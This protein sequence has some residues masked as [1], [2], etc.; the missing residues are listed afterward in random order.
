MNNCAPCYASCPDNACSTKL[1]TMPCNP[2]SNKYWFKTPA[3]FDQVRHNIVNG[4]W[5]CN[6]E[7]LQS[8]NNLL[9]QR[10]FY[11][12][13][14]TPPYNHSYNLNLEPGYRN[15]DKQSEHINQCP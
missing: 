3:K 4:L 8:Q 10:N 15:L 12:G 5:L 13:Y 9:C 1:K 11:D 2:N 6:F 14:I 7:P